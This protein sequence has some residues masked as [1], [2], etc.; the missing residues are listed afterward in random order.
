L[1]FQRIGVNDLGRG[2]ERLHVGGNDGIKIEF[3]GIGIEVR[4]IME[5]DA[6]PEMES[7][8]QFIRG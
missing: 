7:D 4:A 5:F 6:L 1:E 3:N 8:G 2:P